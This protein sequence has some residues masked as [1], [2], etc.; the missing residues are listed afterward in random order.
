MCA[1]QHAREAI[2]PSLKHAIEKPGPA[3]SAFRAPDATSVVVM[4]TAPQTRRTVTQVQ[5]G[6]RVVLPSRC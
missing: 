3:R 4:L 1:N 5:T 2:V 6:C